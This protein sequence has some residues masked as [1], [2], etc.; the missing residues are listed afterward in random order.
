[1][2]IRP[3][4][5]SPPRVLALLFALLVAGGCSSWGR[6]EPITPS[7]YVEAGSSSQVRV[8]LTDGRVVVVHAAHMEGDT[9][10]GL[11]ATSLTAKSAL[12]D[13]EEPR[14]SCAFALRDMKTAEAKRP[15]PTK[16]VILLAVPVGL[17]VAII[18]TLAGQN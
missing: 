3:N 9:L 17:F 16:T 11:C 15:N 6:L 12:F 2:A 10:R 7:A 13:S 18:A 14:D 4:R 8:E 5:L 1:M